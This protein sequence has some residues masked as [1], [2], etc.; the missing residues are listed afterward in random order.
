MRSSNVLWGLVGLLASLSIVIVGIH[1]TVGL[2]FAEPGQL[3]L[4]GDLASRLL[5]DYSVDPVKVVTLKPLS[6]TVV[7]EVIRERRE[8]QTPSP[9]TPSATPMTPPPSTVSPSPTQAEAATSTPQD[10]LTATSTA[11]PSPSLTVTGTASPSP[12]RTVP[13][14]YT[15]TSVPPP[16]QP[17]PTN[18]RRRPT[19]TPAPPPTNT[20]PPPTQPPPTQPPPTQPPYPQPPPTSYP[21]AARVQ[22]G[23][24]DLPVVVVTLGV[25]LMGALMCV[26]LDRG[27]R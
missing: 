3:A 18:T 9:T 5:A 7:E 10:T 27:R 20:P 2:A 15:A 12:S 25:V 1:L 17:P 21:L 22:H 13:P 23:E 24:P 6:T 8:G 11:S 4:P 19:K 26:R 14:S 16:T